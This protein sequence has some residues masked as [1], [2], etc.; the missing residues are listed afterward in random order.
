MD[1]MEFAYMPPWN[2][3]T[4]YILIMCTRTRAD[5]QT[6]LWCSTLYGSYNPTT[7][8]QTISPGCGSRTSLESV[9]LSYLFGILWQPFVLSTT[10][11]APFVSSR[12]Y[13]TNSHGNGDDDPPSYMC[14]YSSPLFTLQI[15]KISAHTNHSMAFLSITMVLLPPNH[16]IPSSWHQHQWCHPYQPLWDPRTS[17]NFLV[18]VP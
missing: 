5:V 17:L 3:T 7:L 11:M 15:V 2:S 4:H 12:L 18:C 1:V 9:P 6:P 14:L 13:V 8:T 16:N 10:T